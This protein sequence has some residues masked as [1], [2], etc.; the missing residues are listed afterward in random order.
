MLDVGLGEKEV[1]S[2]RGSNCEHSDENANLKLMAI[3]EM[4]FSSMSLPN[5]FHP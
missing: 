5:S 4:A 2:C 1:W 3:K